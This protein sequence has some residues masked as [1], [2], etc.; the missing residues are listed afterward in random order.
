MMK[1]LVTMVLALII[2]AP[3]CAI[4]SKLFR[5]SNQAKENF[6]DF[7]I[8]IKE[9]HKK[10]EDLEQRTS[11]LILDDNSLIAFFKKGTDT[12]YFRTGKEASTS[13]GPSSL[14]YSRG[15]SCG[16]EACACLCREFI[17]ENGAIECSK[18]VC[19]DIKEGVLRSSWGMERNDDKDV[20]AYHYR[21]ASIQ[22]KKQPDKSILL[23][24]SPDEAANCDSTSGACEDFI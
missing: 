14:A 19:E 2:F 4:S 8:T 6:V 9:L 16:T 13:S 1:F 17:T 7:V 24:Y 11:I 22:L 5:L 12:I 23:A 21:R 15:R 3:A 20:E 18:S 10:G